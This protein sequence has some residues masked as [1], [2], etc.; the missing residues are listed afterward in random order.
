SPLRCALVEMTK[1][2]AALPATVVAEQDLVEKHFQE[3]T[4]EN[5]DLSTPL[6]SGR[7]DKGEGRAS[8]N[9]SCG[10]GPCRKHISKKR[11]LKTQISPL[12]CAPVEMT[13]GRAALPATVVAVQDPS[14][15][16]S[17]KRRP[18]KTQISPLRCAPVEMTKGRAALPATVV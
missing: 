18:L 2:R 16:H 7:D 15:K 8:C 5:A 4:A 13:K 1:G 9:C 10:T 12:R 3:E 17:S 11:P 14:R 6:R